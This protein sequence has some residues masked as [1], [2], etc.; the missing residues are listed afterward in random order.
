[1][2]CLISYVMG[3][4][5]AQAKKSNMPKESSIRCSQSQYELKGMSQRFLVEIQLGLMPSF[6]ALK[7]DLFRRD[8]VLILIPWLYH[9]QGCK[10]MCS[11]KGDLFRKIP[12]FWIKYFLLIWSCRARAET[13][14][15]T[16]CFSLCS[17]GNPTVES[18][19]DEN[20]VKMWTWHWG[21]V[22]TWKICWDTRHYVCFKLIFSKLVLT[23]LKCLLVLIVFRGTLWPYDGRIPWQK[24]QWCTLP[25]DFFMFTEDDAEWFNIAL[26]ERCFRDLT[27]P[28]Q[29][30]AQLLNC[31]FK[32][33]VVDSWIGFWHIFDL[34]FWAWPM[35]GI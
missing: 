15:W 10:N 26:K 35:L 25:F 9:E 3:H 22:I 29:V 6:L 12:W 24:Y 28:K 1:M 21:G 19:T 33:Y 31:I 2:L 16:R 8:S 4:N 23:S 34:Y 27:D 7:G 5:T 11:E 20:Y 14:A 18:D 30:E 17:R 13:M 32:W